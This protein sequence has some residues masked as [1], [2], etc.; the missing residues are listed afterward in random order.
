MSGR[1][2]LPI[3]TRL[4]SK[5]SREFSLVGWDIALYTQGAG[6]RT[7]VIP[8]IHFKVEFLDTRLFDKK[9]Y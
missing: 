5:L 9:K 1:H 2:M 7:P 3:S 6:I 8:L 4:R